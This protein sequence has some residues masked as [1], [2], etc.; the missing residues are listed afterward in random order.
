MPSG[1]TPSTIR[2][3]DARVVLGNDPLALEGDAS[4]GAEGWR[5]RGM[6]TAPVLT[7]SG[8]PV[9][10]LHAAF[11]VD[12]ERLEATAVSSPHSRRGRPGDGVMAVERGRSSGGPARTG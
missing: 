7:V 4:W 11:L 5:G 2:I 8:W 6:L 10:G 3:A 1:L 9:E 12:A